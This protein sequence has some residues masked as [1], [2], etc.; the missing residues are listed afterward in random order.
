MKNVVLIGAAALFCITSFCDECWSEGF[1]FDGSEITEEAILLKPADPI[2]YSSA[3]AEGKPKS[4][5][6]NVEDISNPEKSASIFADY[7]EIAVEGTTTWNYTDEDFADFPTDDTYLLTETVTSDTEEKVFN[8]KVTILPEP[9]SLFVMVFVGSLFFRKRTKNLIAF[10]T[11]AAL[12]SFSAKADG[13]VSNVNCFQMWPFDRSVIINYTLT[14]NCIDPVFKVKF[15]GSTDNG[16][17]IFDLSEKGTIIRDGANGTVESSGEHK[18]LWI[19]DE[20]FREKYDNMKIKISA[21]EKP[22]PG[23]NTYMIIDLSEGTNA[24]SFAVSYLDDEPDEGWTE[25]YKTAKM[26]LRKIEAG[27]FVMGSPDDEIGRGN[28]ACPGFLETQHEVTLSNPRSRR[29]PAIWGSLRTSITSK[30]TPT[31]RPSSTRAPTGS[32]RSA[33]RHTFI[34]E[35]HY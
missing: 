22:Q 1:C 5:T 3:L 19:P 31:S 35:G 16:E 18:T 17:T 10:L 28:Y 7:S 9:I 4:L 11:F 34:Y 29:S 25:E 14:S 30:R 12:S 23:S 33:P 2:A 32:P 24:T 27:S 20:S 21:K 13:C 15:Y 6:L 8:R 26:V